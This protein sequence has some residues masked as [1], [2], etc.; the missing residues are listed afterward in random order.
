M[1]FPPLPS[2]ERLEALARTLVRPVV[3]L[4]LVAVA[5][6]MVWHAAP[7]PEW[8]KDLTLATVFFWFGSRTNGAPR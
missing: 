4:V 7:L 8:Y 5:S 3:T 6:G 1:A 2:L